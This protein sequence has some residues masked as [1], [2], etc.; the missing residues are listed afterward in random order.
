MAENDAKR[1][2]LIDDDEVFRMSTVRMLQSKGYEMLE[3]DSGAKG[4]QLARQ[5]KPDLVLLDLSMPGTSG[6]QVWTQIRRD[7]DLKAI[8]VLIVT[9]ND[10]D[11]DTFFGES[12]S[13]DDY[14]K[15]PLIRR[16]FLKLIKS[17]LAA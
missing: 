9:A 12:L 7:P 15:K 3:C 14:V 1:I 11:S 16:D 2:L 17:K 6:H 13:A 10:R 4:L 8:T 5:E